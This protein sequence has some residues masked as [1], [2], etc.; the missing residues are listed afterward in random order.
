[1][2]FERASIGRTQR[3]QRPFL[4]TEC[5]VSRGQLFGWS[6]KKLPEWADSQIGFQIVVSRSPLHLDPVGEIKLR[7]RFYSITPSFDYD[8]VVEI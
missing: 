6:K 7:Q 5:G 8:C 3:F 1:L 2:I 4:K